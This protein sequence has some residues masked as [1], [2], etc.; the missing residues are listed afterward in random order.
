MTS[1]LLLAV[2]GSVWKVRRKLLENGLG[3]FKVRGG[4]FVLSDLSA[5]HGQPTVGSTTLGFKVCITRLGFDKV[6][7]ER[8][9]RRDKLS[10]QGQKIRF[11]QPLIVL[12]A[13]QVLINGFF[14]LR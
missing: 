11:F 8:Q 14:G 5:E 10:S 13:I 2:L 7:V 9:S 4:L 6:F 12:D 3:L 1:R